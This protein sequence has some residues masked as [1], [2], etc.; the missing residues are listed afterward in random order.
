MSDTGRPERV[1]GQI[2]RD[3]LETI[4]FKSI[5]YFGL[6][7]TGILLAR[8]LGAEGTGV[9][10]FLLALLQTLEQ[11]GNLGLPVANIYF[12]ARH[13]ERAAA[14]AGNAILTPILIGGTLSLG[15]F[16]AREFVAREFLDGADP[17]LVVL[18]L[19]LLPFRFLE[20]NL[21]SLLRGSMRFRLWNLFQAASPALDFVA[22]Y[23][24]IGVFGGGVTAAVAV[25]TA[26]GTILSIVLFVTVTRLM[27]IA[28]R[29]DLALLRETLTFGVKSYFQVIASFLHHKIDL[30]F[31]AAI[32]STADVA[33]YAAAVGYTTLVWFVPDSI[34]LVLLPRLVLLDRGEI[35]RVTAFVTRC[36]FFVLAM[37]T[38]ASVLCAPAVIPFLYGPEFGPSIEV[39]PILAFGILTMSVG[40]ILFRNFTSQA[41]QGINVVAGAVSLAVNVG[42]NAFLIPRFGIEGAA[43]ATA[44]SYTLSSA[45]LLA[46]FLF[47][48]GL[49]IRETLVPRGEDLRE[50]FSVLAP[51]LS[52]RRGLAARLGRR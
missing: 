8:L 7:A 32:L 39:A 14:V 36:T 17:V 45:I 24:T 48:S 3:S 46:R 22:L 31:V 47:D 52:R 30:W 43:A 6:T 34:G 35:H 11:V 9:L 38:A 5:V 1:E 16:L 40:K 19:A 41:R 33:H 42:L 10:A 50:F 44:V 23:L 49:S 37:A 13:R 28:F 21:Y 51:F 27:P 18:V 26:L 29:F 4:A 25:R 12:I 20:S 15:L 2:G